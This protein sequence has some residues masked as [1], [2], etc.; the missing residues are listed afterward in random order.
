VRRAW[1]F[2]GEVLS[3]WSEDRA[4]RLGAA[5]AY[6]ALFSLAPILVIA[7]AGLAFDRRAVERHVLDQV[8]GLVG[9]QG[10]EAVRAM[11]ESA[12]AHP[13]GGLAAA[14]VGLAALA[15]GATGAFAELQDALNTIWHVKPR[16]GRGLPGLLRDRFLSFAM[17]LAI[18]FLLLVALMVS[19]ALAALAPLL[20]AVVPADVL[21]AVDAVVS[22]G[23]ITALFAMMFK[24]L[25]DVE[26][27]WCDV[28]LGAAVTALLFVV[29][30]VAIGFYLGRVGVASAY[31]AAGSLVVV[32][33]WVYYAAQILFFGAE[34]TAA[35]AAPP[36][37]RLSRSPPDDP[38]VRA[39]AEGAGHDARAGAG[40]LSAAPRAPGRTIPP[41]APAGYAPP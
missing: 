1:E 34:L 9:V 25:P 24:V 8:S 17:V 41:G 37:A 36:A 21:H 20:S 4:P 32:L 23:V 11:L 29:G 27:A 31:G 18:G 15:F 10:A 39:A 7:I 16:P 5:L 6:Y 35:G 19:A 38:V 22:L 28:W 13:T 40:T 3:E 2:L 30:K 14:V 26:V 12:A 33:V